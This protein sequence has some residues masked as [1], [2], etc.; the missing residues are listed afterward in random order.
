[1]LQEAIISELMERGISSADSTT[2]MNAYLVNILANLILL[3]HEHEKSKAITSF[4]FPKQSAVKQ[5]TN[6][7]PPKQGMTQW[8]NHLP[9]CYGLYIEKNQI[10]TCGA[11]RDDNQ[12][13]QSL[14][15]WLK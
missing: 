10:C 6:I 8:R 2:L 5:S 12:I 11:F 3:E 14:D 9:T 4:R 7:K 1:M 15:N 13:Q